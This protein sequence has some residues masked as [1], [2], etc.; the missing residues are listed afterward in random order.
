VGLDEIL[1]E[2]GLLP[3]DHRVEGGARA[4]GDTLIHAWASAAAGRLSL[5]SDLLRGEGLEAVD[6]LAVRRQTPG[7]P[8]RDVAEPSARTGGRG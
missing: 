1:R 7:P 5:V 8:E 2:R 6:L 4:G 3:L